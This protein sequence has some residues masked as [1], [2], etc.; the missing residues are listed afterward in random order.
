[1]SI[2]YTRKLDHKDVVEHFLNTT[3]EIKAKESD[4]KLIVEVEKQLANNE[5][6]SIS[7]NGNVWQRPYNSHESRRNLR[8]I[9]TSELF[10]KK[11]LKN[12]DK[13]KIWSR[14]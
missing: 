9:I 8:N 4:V 5:S 6:Y 1:M 14:W 10:S 3:L 12:D 7:N 13:N 11:R 2:A